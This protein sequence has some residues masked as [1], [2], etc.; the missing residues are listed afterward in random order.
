LPNDIRRA[1][2]TLV[3]SALLVS[4]CTSGALGG[5]S[6]S[7]PWPPGAQDPKAPHPGTITV[8]FAWDGSTVVKDASKM[9]DAFIFRCG[10]ANGNQVPRAEA[11]WCIPVVEIETVSADEAGKPVPPRGAYTVSSSVYGP[12]HLF[13]E[14]VAS[15]PKPRP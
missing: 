12:N 8:K 4:G 9:S 7:K 2:A 5:H 3:L 11:I 6:M 14:H 10:D 13:L 15:A 1:S